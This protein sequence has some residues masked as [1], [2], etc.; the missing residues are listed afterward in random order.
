M[1]KAVRRPIQRRGQVQVDDRTG[2]SS[3]PAAVRVSAKSG[4]GGAYVSAPDNTL[5]NALHTM[6]A[7]YREMEAEARR[8]K[9]KQEAEA[10]AAAKANMA[11]IDQ[12]SGEVVGIRLASEIGSQARS[13]QMNLA[14]AEQHVRS[15]MQ[16]EGGSAA[17][18]KSFLPHARASLQLAGDAEYGKALRDEKDSYLAVTRQGFNDLHAAYD[19]DNYDDYARVRT[20]IF[21]SRNAL[22]ISGQAIDDLE[23]T[24]LV[25]QINRAAMDD[26]I[27]AQELIDLAERMRPDGSPSLAA[28]APNGYATIQ[29][30]R[31]NIAQGI[32]AEAKQAKA[33]AAATLKETTADN[34][35]STLT[36]LQRA[37]T[38]EEAAAWAK[39]NVDNLSDAELKTRYGDHRADVLNAVHAAKSNRSIPGN[40]VAMAE[41]L[42][43]IQQGTATMNNIYNDSRMNPLQK[44]KLIG[45]MRETTQ[46]SHLGYMA[47]SQLAGMMLGELETAWPSSI[48]RSPWSA[49]LQTEP[50]KPP[51]VSPEGIFYQGELLK[52]L[53]MLDPEL[54][55]TKA[56][57]GKMEIMQDVKN[58]ILSGRIR[59]EDHAV[60]PS[61]PVPQLKLSVK[62]REG[63]KLTRNEVHALAKTMNGG[64]TQEIESAYGINY[65]SLDGHEQKRI[66]AEAQRQK[67]ELDALES[68]RFFNRTFPNIGTMDENLY[69]GIT[70]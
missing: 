24:S 40:D 9:E 35:V 52:R 12:I 55:V 4:S 66:A 44:A 28:S 18:M 62:V 11:A 70:H 37:Q 21:E 41:H 16:Q 23:M 25:N 13:G 53:R 19:P 34:Y 61:E 22:G 31:E 69:F 29:T 63:Q 8:M 64:G 54:D 68:E 33:D 20:T 59:W 5:A 7:T 60:N 58:D 67:A 6:S 32:V 38:P 51:V 46:K 3:I 17:F 10:E 49:S 15:I 39:E 30:L 1:P 47:D 50:G 42:G 14:D 48:Y 43:D 26:P 36:A 45:V 2:T 65:F 27:R 56:N 57:Q